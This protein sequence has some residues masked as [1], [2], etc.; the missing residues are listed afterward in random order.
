MAAVDFIRFADES[1][2]D[3]SEQRSEI[4]HD[5]ENCRNKEK[6]QHRCH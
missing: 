6:R 5:Y 1:T 2:E 4:V 3:T